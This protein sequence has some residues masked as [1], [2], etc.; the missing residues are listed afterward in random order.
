MSTKKL[1][2]TS[3]QRRQ[4]LSS[5]LTSLVK[6]ERI[7]TTKA[8]AQF[9]APYADRLIEYALEADEATT[10]TTTADAVLRVSRLL[11]QPE[12]YLKRVFGLL[13]ARK[14]PLLA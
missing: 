8:K 5:L 2:R 3:I 13:S 6:N 12:R 1:S 11:D 9:M 7:R 14:K 4:L 10:T